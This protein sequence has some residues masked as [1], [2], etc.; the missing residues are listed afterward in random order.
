[1][2]LGPFKDAYSNIIKE[3]SENKEY[4]LIFST[5]LAS[6]FTH[7][8]NE[9]TGICAKMVQAKNVSKDVADKF[10]DLYSKIK[11]LVEA[12]KNS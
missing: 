2:S 12:A 5:N 10:D 7:T 9:F 1:M 4:E 3:D 11:N 6:E 8:V